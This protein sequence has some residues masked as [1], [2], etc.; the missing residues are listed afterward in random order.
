MFTMWVPTLNVLPGTRGCRDEEHKSL[1]WKWTE[2][3]YLNI[4]RLQNTMLNAQRQT[5]QLISIIV[6]AFV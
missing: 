4:E 6:E 1:E 2:S 5:A 3:A